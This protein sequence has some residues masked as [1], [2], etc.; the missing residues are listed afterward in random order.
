VERFSRTANRF[1]SSDF[2]TLDG[3]LRGFTSIVTTPY[4]LTEVSNLLGLIGGR[5]RRGCF[6][7]S[8]R[9]IPN[10]SEQ[11]VASSKLARAEQF[12]DLGITDTSILEV[13]AAP[14]LVLT[15][16]FRLYNHLAHRGIDLLNFNNL[17]AL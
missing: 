16:D 12:V 7:L 2:D 11:Q 9:S 17:R 1:I 4:I 6:E 5:A 10:L 3:V 15:D 8:A 14:Y 13:A